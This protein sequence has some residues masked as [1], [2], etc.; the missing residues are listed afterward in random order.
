MTFKQ[1]LSEWEGFNFAQ[2]KDLVNNPAIQNSKYKGPC[3]EKEC[4]P[5]N[6]SGK[7]EKQFGFSKNDELLRITR[8][9]K[10]RV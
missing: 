2:E 7:V 6:Q 9:K 8:M 5:M 3:K 1:W 10:M 4:R